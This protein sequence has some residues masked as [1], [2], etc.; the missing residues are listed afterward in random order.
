MLSA[1][2][3]V[4]H[5][6]TVVYTRAVAS[7]MMNSSQL[8]LFTLSGSVL[9]HTRLK[10]FRFQTLCSRKSETVPL[11]KTKKVCLS[12]D[13]YLMR[14]SQRREILHVESIEHNRSPKIFLWGDTVSA[15]LS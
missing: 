5:S 13:K 8:Y 7:Y 10:L 11:V 4:G 3:V 1:L 15:I 6:V 14:T 9:H 2:F 12:N